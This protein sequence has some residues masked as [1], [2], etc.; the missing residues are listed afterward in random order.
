MRILH[1]YQSSNFKE[2]EIYTAEPVT[3][4]SSLLEVY[5]PIKK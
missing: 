3:S 4:E 1:F 2:S 5:I